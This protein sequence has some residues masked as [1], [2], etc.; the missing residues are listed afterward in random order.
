MD[1]VIGGITPRGL[2][3]FGVYSERAAMPQTVEQQVTPE[4]KLGAVIEQ[5]GKDGIV[6]EIDVDL[7]LTVSAAADLRDWLTARIDDAKRLHAAEQDAQDQTN[8]ASGG[9]ESP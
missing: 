8:A 2:I 6:R 7:I 9:R 5:S 4:G 3:H 1:G